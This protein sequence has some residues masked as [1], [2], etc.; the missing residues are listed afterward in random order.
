MKKSILLVIGAV[1]SLQC[2]VLS[3]IKDKN[4]VKFAGKFTELKLKS[5]PIIM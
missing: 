1:M 3:Q 5:F 2:C 4:F